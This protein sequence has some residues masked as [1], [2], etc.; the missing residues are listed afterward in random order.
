MGNSVVMTVLFQMFS[1][2]LVVSSILVITSSSSVLSLVF[3]IL[4]FLFASCLLF[5][6]ECEFLAL[7]FIIVYVGAIAVLFLFAIMMLETKSGNVERNSSRYLPTPIIL[8]VLLLVPLI[9]QIQAHFGPS[10][11]TLLYSNYNFYTNYYQN[12]YD[13]IDSANDIDVYG[14]VLYSYYVLQ[15][16]LTGFTLLLVLIGAVYLTNSFEKGTPKQTGFKQLARKAKI[17]RN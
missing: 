13:L 10:G 15:F 6:L 17:F 16:L 11:N 14:Q 7:L 5:L 8:G 3:L 1:I 2:F 4:T 12:W 9:H